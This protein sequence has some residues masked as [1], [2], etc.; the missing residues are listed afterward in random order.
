MQ[1]SNQGK[2]RPQRSIVVALAGNPN[3][4][5]TTIFNNL[6]GANQHVANFPGVTVE[7]KEGRLSHNGFRF[8]F[9]DLPGAYSLAAHSP[10]EV[11][12]RDFILKD[13]PDIV[14]DIVD[15]TSLER[16]LYLTTQ[17]AE[18]DV[19]I[20]L[21]LNM[22]DLAQRR[23][24]RINH[25]QLADLLGMKVVP[26][27]GNKRKGMAELLEALVA[28][29]ENGDGNK[30]V[31]IK[32]DPEFRE[33]IDALCRSIQSA[34]NLSNGYPHGWLAARLLENDQEIRRYFSRQSDAAES[35]AQAEQSRSRIETLFGKT[36]TDYMTGRRYDFIGE[37]CAA[38][39]TVPPERKR[40]LSDKLDSVL[41]HPIF[42]LPIFALLMWLMFHL[43]FTLGEKPTVWIEWSFARLADLAYTYVP[44]TLV[45]SL[46]AD[47][48]IG[49]VGGVL[50][51]LPNIMILFLAIAVI[52][53]TGYIARAAF[54]MDRIMHRIGLHGKS[55]IPMLIGFG[56]S[57]PAYL[58]S[59][60]IENR[61]DRL[62]TMHVTSFMSCSARLPVYE[63]DDLLY[64][65]PRAWRGRL[66]A[67][68][69][70]LFAFEELQ[71]DAAARLS[72]AG[73]E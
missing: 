51:F 6:T 16:G 71:L 22:S 31:Q 9:I 5:K 46:V 27:V 21:A 33:E 29:I 54:V 68:Q 40:D 37:V 72:V 69:V 10:D 4:G 14:V 44:G 8:T 60:I 17:L 30:P 19:P 28:T 41:L 24:I 59:R 23:G 67:D 43:T 61:T 42:G 50:V 53:D 35:L 12:V 32:F 1:D 39:T 58:G 45:K 56:C 73:D 62:V 52:E 34:P 57:V 64:R 38:T 7:K 20:V 13:R 15:A 48:I 11:I 26:T 36:A 63:S 65:L 2:R 55:F 66:G 47:G 18:L 49:G 3:S 70:V 25:G